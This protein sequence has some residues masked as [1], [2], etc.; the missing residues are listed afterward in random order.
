[1]SLD[2]RPIQEEADLGT[3]VDVH[4]RVLPTP[5]TIEEL[6]AYRAEFDEE[7]LVA[8]RSG[9]PVGVA[10]AAIERRHEGRPAALG[11][12]LVLTEERS[13]GVGS[14][15]HLAI[16]AWTGEKGVDTLEGYVS[17]EDDE[18]LAWTRRRGFR[19]VGR[20]SRL[21]LDLTAIDA[22]QINPPP[23]IEL[24]R[25]SERPELTRGLYEVACEAGPDIP[26]MP[27][28]PEPF[29]DWLAHDMS[30][31]NDRPE[32]TFV[33]LAGE[34][35]VGYAKFHLPQATPTVAMHD[36]TGVKRAWRRRG[37][38]GALKR[39]Q[40][41]WAKESGYERLETWNEFRNEPI[42]RLNARFGYRQIPGRVLVR[43]DVSPG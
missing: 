9:Q 8:R 19:E 5:A 30:G 29:E 16:S 7:H 18:S 28:D 20:D 42:R 33:A 41:A 38:A 39:A 35:V 12:I 22:P 3:W 37:I 21:A 23:G 2:I 11:A 6:R 25:W 36:L 34:E 40:V 13:H 27:G 24:V 43:A 15:L 17:E 26:G 31:P 4:N 10:F 1:V 14:A 32:G